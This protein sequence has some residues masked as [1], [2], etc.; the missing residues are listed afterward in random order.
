MREVMHFRSNPVLL[1]VAGAN[2]TT[3]ALK[4]TIAL[5]SGTFRAL[6]EFQFLKHRHHRPQ[7]DFI[8]KKI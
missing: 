4:G 6:C 3:L 5:H 8:I 7:L 2:V 1:V